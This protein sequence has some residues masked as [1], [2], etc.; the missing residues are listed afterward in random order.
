MINLSAKAKFLRQEYIPLLQKLN[1]QTEPLWGKMN[2]QQMIE[3]MADAFAEAYG[4]PVQALHTPE[5]HLE[6]MQDFLKSE[7]PFKEN[8]PNKLLPENPLPERF[9]SKEEA[10][11]ELQQEVANFFLAFESEKKKYVMN[12]FF[13]E[14]DYGMSIQLLHKHATHHLRQFGVA[15]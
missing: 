1:A 4:N 3:H 2:V 13:G 8:T 5:E 12:P 14:L 11:E 15:V 7:K 6:K 9:P 10:V